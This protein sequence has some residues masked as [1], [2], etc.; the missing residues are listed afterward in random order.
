MALAPSNS[1][2]G[3]V[4]LPDAAPA[5]AFIALVFLL[6][7]FV[8]GMVGLGLPIVGVGLLSLVTTPQQASALLVVPSMVTN[9]WQL[10]AGPGL[11]ALARRLWPMMAGICAG[12]WAGLWALGR[13]GWLTAA[14]ATRAEG[15]LGL[16]LVLYAGL[17][18][19]RVQLP[20]PG[21][22]E[23]WAGPVVGALTGAVSSFTGVFA[24]P[25]VPYLASLGLD[26]DEL[27]QA[28]GLSFTVS[29][30]ALAAGL[31]AGGLFGAGA[32]GLSALAVLPAVAGLL[33]GGWLRGRVRPGTFRLCFLLGVAGLG[34]HLAVRGLA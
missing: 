24:I 27:I 17:S 26:R 22:A 34:L 6:A 11:G 18:L 7:G 30:V 32:A 19:L 28:L 25:A 12:T 14:A 16:A 23:R 31:A 2:T 20:P 13:L 5:L 29:T 9:V 3:P 10:L 15:A 21:R 1:Y 8:K 33:A 4:P